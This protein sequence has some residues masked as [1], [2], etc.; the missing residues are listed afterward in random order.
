[1][2]FGNLT[3]CLESNWNWNRKLEEPIRPHSHVVARERSLSLFPS[4]PCP[5]LELQRDLARLAVGVIASEESIVVLLPLLLLLLRLSGVGLLVCSLKHLLH[6]LYLEAAAEGDGR[7]AWK[8]TLSH[9]ID[10]CV[11][12]ERKGLLYLQILWPP[13][14]CMT[15]TWRGSGSPESPG[16]RP[17]QA[18]RYPARPIHF[19]K[20]EMM[21]SFFF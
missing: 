19:V 4:V 20:K 11:P 1:M 7:V 5:H 17:W 16:E 8:P 12:F 9:P 21:A 10:Q 15:R 3:K 14:S 6:H 13:P 18:A 2:Y